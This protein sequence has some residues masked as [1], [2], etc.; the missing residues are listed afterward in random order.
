MT[1]SDPSHCPR[2]NNPIPDNAPSGL[3]PAC[4]LGGAATTSSRTIPGA[5]T[6]PPSVDELAVHFPD[7]EIMEVIGF[8]GMGAV[9]KARQPKLDRLVALKILHV[10]DDDPAFEERFNREA[11]VLARLNH[12][13]IVT[14]FDFGTSGPF[15]FLIMER[16]YQSPPS[17][18][19]RTLCP[20]R[21]A[22]LGPGNVRGAEIRP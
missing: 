7:L 11:R 17:H 21:G 10:H 13:N 19:S 3:C 22:H 12:P 2:C 9:Y 6:Q 14:V 4:V 20:G 8:G 15:H 1:N 5:K 18:A 16:R